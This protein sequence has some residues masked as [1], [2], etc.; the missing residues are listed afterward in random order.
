[1][2]QRASP[3][4]AHRDALIGLVWNVRTAAD[5]E[6]SISGLEPPTR[7]PA[8]ARAALVDLSAAHL[9]ADTHEASTEHL[10]AA[11]HRAT[12]A[13]QLDSGDAAARFNQALALDRLSLTGE[14]H[15]AW[16]AYLKTD[17]TSQWAA[18]A[19]RRIDALID[20]S[21]PNPSWQQP[22]SLRDVSKLQLD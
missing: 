15:A 19:R 3:V 5:A 16:T 1:A 8:T 9:V 13:L 18:E 17:S 14:A 7:D 10:L 20:R 12:R 2:H 6:R 4:L 21:R 22:A 11:P